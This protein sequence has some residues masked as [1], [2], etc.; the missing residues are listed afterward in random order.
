LTRYAHFEILK[1]LTEMVP[2]E[3]RT[4]Y[5]KF[6][7]T[8]NIEFGDYGRGFF[9]VDIYALYQPLS[10]RWAVIIWLGTIDDGDYGALL[11]NLDEET[12]RNL[13]ERV[14]NEVFKD[15]VAFPTQDELNKILRPYGLYVTYK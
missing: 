2:N 1:K 8:G 13:V 4:G 3:K 7:Q 15:M 5:S 11:E 9:D 6:I 12:A 10:Q 14:A